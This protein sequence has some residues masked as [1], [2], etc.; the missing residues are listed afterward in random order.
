ML[1][2]LDLSF[3]IA[4]AEKNVPA[5]RHYM[6]LSAANS[7]LMAIAKNPVD[8]IIAATR[9]DR[10][11]KKIGLRLGPRPK[12]EFLQLIAR[13]YADYVREQKPMDYNKSLKL[14]SEEPDK[15]DFSVKESHEMWYYDF[16]YDLPGWRKLDAV[17]MKMELDSL[18]FLT[19]PSWNGRHDLCISMYSQKM[20]L[21]AVVRQ[22]IDAG[23][24]NERIGI[25]DNISRVPEIIYS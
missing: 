12:T 10:F 4:M 9:Y 1:L 24:V 23:M 5:E 3:K 2:P 22:Q 6:F 14:L 18:F 19:P 17:L 15:M 13:D 11:T 20:P 21:T 7:R 8:Y 25:D 16:V